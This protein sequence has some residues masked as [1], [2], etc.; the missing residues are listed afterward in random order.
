M[1]RPSMEGNGKVK[2]DL[3]MPTTGKHPHILNSLIS[4]RHIPF[5]Y[6]FYLSIE[7][8]TWP[9]A[10]NLAFAETKNDVILM[11]D[12]I[13]F[14]PDTFKNLEE[15]YDDAE[16]FGFRLM[17]LDG[18][19]QPS[20]I[21]DVPAVCKKLKCPFRTPHYNHGP[22]WAVSEKPLYVG[23]LSTSL[24][25]IKRQVIEKIQMRED[26][27]GMLFEDN[28]FM[29]RAVDAGFRILF[30][31]NEAIHLG[32]MTKRHDPDFAMKQ[33]FNWVKLKQLHPDLMKYAFVKP[34]KEEEDA[35]IGTEV[36]GSPVEGETREDSG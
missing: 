36:H 19:V 15:Y 9:K 11:D 28:D 24:C 3:I 25:I 16:I 23:Y 20:G 26:W 7:G 30:I 27:P 21:E 8:D 1:D 31:P 33:H 22:N 34:Y 5:P 4:F 14:H 2:F 12:D 17:R 10:V 29:F 32:S 13:I 18:Q 35:R 6:T